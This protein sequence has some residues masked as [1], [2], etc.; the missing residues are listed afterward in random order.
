[1]FTACI[2]LVF[3]GKCM[4]FQIICSLLFS[5]IVDTFEV[6]TLSYQFSSTLPL[7]T[8]PNTVCV[9]GHAKK[10]SELCYDLVIPW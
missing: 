3:A 10:V 9:S 8:Y 6:Y 1:M 2:S 7:S 5:I 4:Q